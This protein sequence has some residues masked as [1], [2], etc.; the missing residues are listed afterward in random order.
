MAAVETLVVVNGADNWQLEPGVH[1]AGMNSS[2]LFDVDGAML[3]QPWFRFRYLGGWV[4]QRLHPQAWF[5]IDGEFIDATRQFKLPEMVPGRPITLTV[6]IGDHRVHLRISLSSAV[7]SSSLR[8]PAVTAADAVSNPAELISAKHA[9][10][11]PPTPARGSDNIERALGDLTRWDLSSRTS[12]VVGRRGG[13]ADVQADGV[14]I[15]LSHV[16]LRWTGD[17]LD[18]RSLAPRLRPVVRGAP[19]LQARVAV[20]EHFMVGHSTF[21]ISGAGLLMLVP[22]SASAGTALLRLRNVTLQYKTANEPT[23]RDISFDLR[24]HEVLAV[25]GPSGAGKSTLCGAFTGEVKL[26]GGRLR[27]R[28]VDLSA[29]GGLVSNLVSFVPQQPDLYPELGVRQSLLQVAGLRLATDLA[30][31]ERTRRVEEVIE[32]VQLRRDIDKLAGSLSGGQK[33]RLSIA[34]ELLSD[35]LLLVLDEPTSGLDEGLDRDLMRLLREIAARGCAV[36][37]V[38]HSMVN[39][40]QA[41]LVL[42]IAAGGQKGYF[43]PPIGLQAAFDASD[44]ATV[45]D[46]LRKNRTGGT[47]E[48][49]LPVGAGENA[50]HR[51]ERTRQFNHGQLRR[52]VSR[53]FARQRAALRTM[54]RT[55]ILYPMLVV[56]LISAAASQG[57]S[58]SESRSGARA[59]ALIMIVCLTF[60]SLSLSFSSIVGDRN[61]L[62][63]EAR[64]GISAYSVIISRMIAFTPMALWL[65][66]SSMLGAL[67]VVPGSDDPLLSGPTG[68]LVVGCLIPLVSVSV[69]LLISTV[70]A[71]LRQAVFVLMGLLAAEVVLTGLAIPFPSGGTGDALRIVSDVMPTRWAAA[72]LG[73]ETGLDAPPK[74]LAGA[75]EQ[76]FI[77]PFDTDAIWAHTVGHFWTAIGVLA[78]GTVLLALVAAQVLSAQLHKRN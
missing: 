73:S 63:R 5:F 51:S 22:R 8:G 34:M 17:Y 13:P 27:L 3:A 44:Y 33:K 45:M 28:E 49:L 11:A 71:N 69:G 10:N 60:F 66:L 47:M 46:R 61:I 59:A 76:A 32:Q 39:L 6:A 50:R 70:A 31:T 52:L 67:L 14:D 78:G 7:A 55:M 12:V 58:V 54:V 20:G 56:A 74:R 35:P 64:W 24:A 30:E 1:L 9:V 68:M 23:T 15:A 48:P 72:A 36:I 26:V 29:A 4:V 37:V 77:S 16:R 65:G 43:G 40:D 53:E 57:F 25:I 21:V 19:V 41:D 38:T 62:V 2:I 75:P 18:V 42:A